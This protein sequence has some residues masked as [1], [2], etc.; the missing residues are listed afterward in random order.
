MVPT[1]A[2]AERPATVLVVDDEPRN[3]RCVSRILKRVG[4]VVHEALA[5]DAALCTLA[6]ASIDLV[7]T[8]YRMPDGGGEALIA[9]LRREQPH[10][11]IICATGYADADVPVPV[12]AKPFESRE[13]VD[14]VACVLRP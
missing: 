13:L 9:W 11:A 4:F 14:L 10:V 3:V 2:H 6:S 7:I 1:V 8:D 12:L 5:V